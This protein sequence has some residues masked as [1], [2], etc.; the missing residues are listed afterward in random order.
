[1][2]DGQLRISDAERERAAG[3]LGEH[4]AQGRLTSEEHTERLDRIWSSRTRA[5]L[6]PVF[7]D[8]PGPHG[9]QTPPAPRAAPP[10]TSALRHARRLPTPILVVVALLVALTVLTHLPLILVGLVGWFLISS[11]RRGGQRRCR[12]IG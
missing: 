5:E 10:R 6:G 9:P 2:N 12:S 8:L 4:Y 7:A 3:E 11:H 1:V